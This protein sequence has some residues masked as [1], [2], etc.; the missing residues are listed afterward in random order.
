MVKYFFY[1]MEISQ[2]I[3][4]KG[5]RP[6]FKDKMGFNLRVG[7]ESIG[8]KDRIFEKFLWQEYFRS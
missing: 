4:N 1:L 3:K 5:E 2:V 6:D 7:I 8:W